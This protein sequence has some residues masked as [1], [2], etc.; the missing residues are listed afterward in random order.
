MYC[1]FLKKDM[2]CWN[3]LEFKELI[4]DNRV[5]EYTEEEVVLGWVEREGKKSGQCRYIIRYEADLQLN[6]LN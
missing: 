5:P 6:A 1:I 3:G 2:Q 4:L